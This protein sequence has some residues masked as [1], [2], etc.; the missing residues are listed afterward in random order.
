VVYGSWRSV[1]KYVDYRSKTP[2]IRELL[3][4][5]AFGDDG[6]VI[7]QADGEGEYA[8]LELNDVIPGERGPVFA[9]DLGPEVN[10]ALAEAFA[11]RPVYRLT[12]TVSQ[13]EGKRVTVDSVPRAELVRPRS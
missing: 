13:P 11:D 2:L 9:R 6:L 7:V 4:A 3:D 12:L 1:S 10:A 8:A 5:G